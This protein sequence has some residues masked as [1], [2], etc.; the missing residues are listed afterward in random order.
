MSANLRELNNPVR[1]LHAHDLGFYFIFCC[2]WTRR[3]L[4]CR[5]EVDRSEVVVTAGQN[6]VWTKGL[7][8]ATRMPRERTC[9]TA[10]MA[11]GLALQRCCVQNF[12]G[13]RGSEPPE[14]RCNRRVKLCCGWTRRFLGCLVR[15]PARQPTRLKGLPCIGKVLLGST[16]MAER[17]RPKPHLAEG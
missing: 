9:P 14:G 5:R 11:K 17:H 12:L 4:G 3:F 10:L 13:C 16:W 1:S 2:G 8:R 6:A 15:G 7:L